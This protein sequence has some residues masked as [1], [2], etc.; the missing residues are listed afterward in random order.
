MREDRLVLRAKQATAGLERWL[1]QLELAE[2]SAEA[3][4]IHLLALK[5]TQKEF[6]LHAVAEGSGVTSVRFSD[7]YLLLTLTRARLLRL[8]LRAVSA[9]RVRWPDW[10]RKE[11]AELLGGLALSYARDRDLTMVAAI[12]RVAGRLET[13]DPLLDEACSFLLDQQSV[14]GSFGLFVAESMQAD[15]AVT[16]LSGRLRFAVDAVSALSSYLERGTQQG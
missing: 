16:L 8:M 1:S 2:L 7:G 9:R 3:Q 12:V 14:D 5:L 13:R 6:L 11:V 10:P 4:T 15:Q